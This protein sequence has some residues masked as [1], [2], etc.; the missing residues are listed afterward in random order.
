MA[1]MGSGLVDFSTMTDFD[2]QNN[3]V[4]LI[5]LKNDSV[6]ADSQAAKSF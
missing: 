6:I 4:C 5:D 3:F 2:D 1:L